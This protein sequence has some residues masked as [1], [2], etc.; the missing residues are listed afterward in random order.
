MTVPPSSPSVLV[1]DPSAENREVLRTILRQ[2]GLQLLEADEAVTGAAL[3][4]E[5]HP[6]VIVLDADAEDAGREDVELQ[7]RSELSHERS[8]LIILGKLRRD[9]M[10]P[11]S[12]ELSKPY[13][14]APLVHT[15]ETL[16]QAAKA[17]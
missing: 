17:A 15:I 11:V 7:L 13:H 10:L 6:S 16:A 4:R 1:V 5:H 8:A 9:S 2:R 14:Y 12:R 3:A